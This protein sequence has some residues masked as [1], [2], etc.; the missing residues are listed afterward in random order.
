MMLDI[1][2]A[3][4]T[5]IVG[6]YTRALRLD[7]Y[8]PGLRCKD[9]THQAITTWTAAEFNV[10]RCPTCETFWLRKA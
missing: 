9:L 8:T 1:P 10:V 3:P 2:D 4:E 6:T 5:D 7:G